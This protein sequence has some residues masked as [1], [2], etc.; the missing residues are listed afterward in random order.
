MATKTENSNAK[1]QI[2]LDFVNIDKLVKKY[3]VTNKVTLCILTPCYTGM[4][5]V[6]YITS[7]MKSKDV[8]EEYG[9][10]VHT[11]FCRRD[12]LVS[13]ARNNLVAL[14]MS[15][16]KTTHMLFI[17]SDITWDPVDVLKLLVA[18]KNLVGGIYPLKNY[19]WDHL[20]KDPNDPSNPNP[21]IIQKWIE[22]KNNSKIKNNIS[23]EDMIRYKLVNYNLH[24]LDKDL[25][26]EH[27][28]ARVK[29]LPTGF[30]MFKRNLIEKMAQAFPST[31][32]DDDI[33][34]L[35][36]DQ[37]EF[38]Y[39]LFDCG[40]EDGHYISEDFLFCKRWAKMGGSIWIDVTINLTHSGIEDYKGS[41]LTSII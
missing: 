12:S 41:F 35:K 5:H 17:D 10:E 27:N 11:L 14:A 25:K 26:I 32:Y 36:H 29:Y 28:L 23:D 39:A 31:K 37:N 30:M 9:I 15:N 21:N 19:N 38:A 3:L 6:N 1:T 22:E 40:V 13:R 33:Q 20:L 24:F 18:N 7:L 8:L 2:D 4:C 34:F 16:P